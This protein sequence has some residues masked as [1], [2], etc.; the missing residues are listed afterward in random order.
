MLPNPWKEINLSPTS[1]PLMVIC[2]IDIQ[3]LWLK[4]VRSPY[5]QHLPPLMEICETDISNIYPLWWRAEKLTSNTSDE[6]LWDRPIFS[7]YT[8]W[9]RCVRSI[10]S[11]FYYLW[12]AAVRSTYLQHLP[13]L[14]RSWRSEVEQAQWSSRPRVAVKS[15]K[16]KGG[17]RDAT[18]HHCSFK[19]SR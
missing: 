5:L 4:A 1:I 3:H 19:V 7:I 18:S 8:L 2:E 14:T 11:N 10:F 6:K 12:R 16:G 17:R 9:W 15:L 13:P